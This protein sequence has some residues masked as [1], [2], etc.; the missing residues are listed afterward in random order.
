MQVVELEDAVAARRSCSGAAPTL[1]CTSRT[2]WA[3]SSN[4]CNQPRGVDGCIFTA[5]VRRCPMCGSY[6]Q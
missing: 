3:A 2:E 4:V 5:G 6:C 1:Q